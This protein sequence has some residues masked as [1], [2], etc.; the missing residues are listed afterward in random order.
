MEPD[1]TPT[2]A[3][4]LVAFDTESATTSGAPHL[5]EVGAVRVVDGEVEDCFEALVRPPVPVEDEATRV[6]GINDA[7]VR[8][9][10]EAQEVL[11]DFFAWI[12]DATLVA[13]NARADA[14]VL[15]F[16]CARH[17]LTAPANRIVD[18]LALARTVFPDAP[19]HRLP[20]LAEHLDLEID[21][22]HRA[23]PD[24]V[25]CWKVYEA[26]LAERTDAALALVDRAAIPFTLA[27]SLPPRPNRRPAQLR[28]LERAR[29]EERTVV[30]HYGEGPEA[31]ARLE[32]LP[33]L[34]YRRRERSYLEGECRSSGTLKTYR[35][36][37]VQRVEAC[38]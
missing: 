22:L 6:H 30:L 29:T 16:E 18:S 5:L 36:D 27:G 20:T 32:V 21:G 11:E 9:A 7:A 35:L 17:G 28:V 25:A 3:T 34:L 33:R 38:S 23:L 10:R 31:P 1:R 26:C 12:G 15:G 14:S 24:A 13:H 2:G 19:D 37:R 8:D 4:L